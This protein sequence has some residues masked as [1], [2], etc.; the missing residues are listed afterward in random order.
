[1]KRLTRAERRARL[2]GTGLMRMDS[3]CSS[4]AG[5]QLD[6]LVSAPPVTE[7]FPILQSVSCVSAERPAADRGV[8]LCSCPADGTR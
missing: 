7:H 6:L 8:S 5:S 3:C 2:M 4:R 1:M